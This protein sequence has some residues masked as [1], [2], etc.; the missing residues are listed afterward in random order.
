MGLDVSGFAQRTKAPPRTLTADEQA[1]LLKVSGEHK[2]GFRDHVIFS[3]ALGTAMRISEIVGLDMYEVDTKEGR[4]RRL[5]QLQRFKGATSARRPADPKAQR[6]HLPDATYYKLE[7]WI[8]VRRRMILVARKN[9]RDVG[10]VF[11]SREG[12]RLH[13]RSLRDAWYAWQERAGLDHRYTFHELRHTAISN[14]Y[15]ETGG[16]L[17]LAQRVAR[18]ANINT[19]TRY[20]HASDDQVATAVRKLRA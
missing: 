9:W 17:R 19:T 18:H 16:N 2:D 8:G 15:A 1:R 4:V 6:V 12:H 10:P 14:V 13:P 3:L 5:I 11:F 7:K 20:E